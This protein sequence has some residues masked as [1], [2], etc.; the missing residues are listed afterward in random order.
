MFRDL[1]AAEIEYLHGLAEELGREQARI[2]PMLGRDADPGV[3]RLVQGMAFLSARLRQRLD[4][5]LPDVVHP[6]IES[7]HPWLLR[8]MPSATIME[9][10]PDPAMQ[11]PQVARAASVFASR[12]SGGAPCLFRSTLDA[13]VRPWSLDG[14]DVVSE[15][16][17][18]RLRFSLLSGAAFGAP[19]GSLRL[20]FAMPAGAALELRSALLRAT[21]TVIARTPSGKGEIALASAAELVGGSAG[22]EDAFEEA[23]KDPFFAL[24]A[25][26]T[27]PEQFAFVAI[28]NLDRLAALGEKVRAFEIVFR[29]RS[30]LPKSLHLDATSVRLHCVPAVNVR[31]MTSLSAPLVGER[32]AIQP[33]DAQVYAIERVSVVRENL[34]TIVAQPYARFFP[35]PIG[36]NGHLPLLYRVSRRGSVVGPELDLGLV[37]VH[38]ESGRL[39]ADAASVDVELFV[40]DGDRAARVSVGEVCVPTAASPPLV[41]FRNITPVTRSAPAVVDDDRLWRWFQLLKTNF[42]QLTDRDSLAAALAL[43]NVAAW[44]RW[45]ASKANADSFEAIVSVRTQRLTRAG[46]DQ[47]F[48]GTHIDVDLNEDHFA[49]RGDIDLL[50]ECLVSLLASTLRTHEWVELALRD[51][52]G[53]AL[54]DYASRFGTRVVL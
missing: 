49:S 8:P 23:T 37:F 12:P 14:V 2:A 22:S 45:P 16:T 31:R 1:Y 21:E 34:S 6:V 13:D 30:A 47:V 38:A 15:R 46:Q 20:F 19:S 48:P 18:I 32:C 39:P 43:A 5:D 9:L 29:L 25:Y 36:D 27:W 35:P 54:F 24:R 53:A 26:F 42:V 11:E 28:P 17:E 4:D 3:S 7:L 41:S 50:G 40:T 44:A 52:Q 51:A 33:P 10:V